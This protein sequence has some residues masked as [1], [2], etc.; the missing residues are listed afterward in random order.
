MWEYE[1]YRTQYGER[2]L[3][4]WIEALPLDERTVIRAKM[5]K[6][7][8]EGL[9]L[10]RTNMMTAIQGYSGDFYELRGGKIRVGVYFNRTENTFILLHG[11]RKTRQR[12]TRD[13]EV[14]YARLIDYLSLKGG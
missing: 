6:L 10:L 1:Y 13:I 2:P 14:A 3:R 7:S 8:E 5:Q 4:D 11:W 9:K 12:Q